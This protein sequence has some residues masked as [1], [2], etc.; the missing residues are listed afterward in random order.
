M[1]F[2]R[3]YLPRTRRYEGEP[4]PCNFWISCLF[5]A[6][7]FVDWGL[8]KPLGMEKLP[9][10]FILLKS[11]VKIVNYTWNWNKNEKVTCLHNAKIWH[12]QSASTT[13][14]VT[15]YIQSDNLTLNYPRTRSCGSCHG[16]PRILNISSSVS[17]A[18]SIPVAL[19]LDCCY[20]F[21]VFFTHHLLIWHD[22]HGGCER[23]YQTTP[24]DL[25]NILEHWPW[26]EWHG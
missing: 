11:H 1:I 26:G 13:T 21:I 12:I 18:M 19:L 24:S 7:N 2:L 23:H 17:E 15:W 9:R 22:D 10:L 8:T 5:N 16:T 6:F 20:R 3:Y 14:D 25:V 4:W